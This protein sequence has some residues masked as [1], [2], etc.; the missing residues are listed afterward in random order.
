MK[1]YDYVLVGSGLMQV[2]GRTRQKSVEKPV[3]LW[4]NAITLAEMCIVRR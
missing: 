2:Y 1:K 4:K 3:W